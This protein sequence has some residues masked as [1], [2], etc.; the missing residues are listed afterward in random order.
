MYLTASMH[1]IHEERKN[2]Q[3]N[4]ALKGLRM[5]FVRSMRVGDSNLI[6]CHPAPPGRELVCQPHWTHLSESRQHC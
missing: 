5:K 2:S 6:K 1:V 3:Q 4:M